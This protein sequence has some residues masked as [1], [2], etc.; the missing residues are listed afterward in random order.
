MTMMRRD[1][2]GA[3]GALF[4]VAACGGPAGPGTISVSASGAAGMNP[5]PDGS[6]RPLT[7]TILQLSSTSGFDSADFFAL[8]DAANTLASDVVGVEQI[9]LAPGASAQASF[10]VKAGA[11]ALGVVAGFRDPGGKVFRATVPVAPG[12]DVAITISVGSGGLTLS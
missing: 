12:D 6:D 11:T 9:A 10:P 2:M 3:G 8:Q 5:G 1:V 7:V 4:L